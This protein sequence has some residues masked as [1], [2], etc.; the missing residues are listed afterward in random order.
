M[1]LLKVHTLN[2]REFF[3]TDVPRYCILSHRWGKDELSYK[4]FKKQDDLDGHGYRKILEFCSFVR[5]R[6]FQEYRPVECKNPKAWFGYHEVD[7]VWVDTICIDK[8]SS[9]ELSEAINSMFAWYEKAVECHVYLHDVTP[10]TSGRLIY[11]RVRAST[12]FSRGWT[13][14]ELLAPA[15]VVFVDSSWNVLGHICDDW[16]PTKRTCACNHVESPTLGP[17]LSHEVSQITSIPHKYLKHKLGASTHA[18]KEA[19]IAQCMSWASRRSTTRLEDEA[20]C[21]LGIFGINMPLIYGEGR[22]AFTRLQEEVIKRSTDQ[23][24]FAWTV[25]CVQAATP[26][27][28]LAHSTGCFAHSGTISKMVH[29]NVSWYGLNNKGLIVQARATSSSLVKLGLIPKRGYMAG[30]EGRLLLLQLNCYDK[31]LVGTHTK[32]EAEI[33]PSVIAVRTTSDGRWYRV[34]IGEDLER[35]VFALKPLTIETQEYLIEA[36]PPEIALHTFKEEKRQ[37]QHTR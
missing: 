10:V 29:M 36:N 26:I 14:Q 11:E 7:W 15:V 9:S 2:F 8:R 23:S 31:E 21:L 3:D 37:R 25:P 32:G 5:E 28:L 19:S 6:N 17:R 18:F 33:Q 1:R 12:W 30:Y 4:E 22:M 20:Y 16:E 27:R 13:L 34:L 35:T 24:I